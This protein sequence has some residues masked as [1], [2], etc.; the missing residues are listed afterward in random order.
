[1]HPATDLDALLKSVSL[2]LPGL[3]GNVAPLRSDQLLCGGQGNQ[4]RIATLHDYWQQ[5]HP[6][7][8]RHYWSTRCWTLLIW[9]PI[10]P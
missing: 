9:Q 10:Y 2:C 1:M 3:N 5:A 7:A 6:E 4:E 8:G